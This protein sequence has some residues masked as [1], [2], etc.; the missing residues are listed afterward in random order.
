VADFEE[1]IHAG[2]KMIWSLIQ[3][4]GCRFHLTQSWWRKIQEIGL[5]DVYKNKK[6]ESGI[7]LRKIFGL[8]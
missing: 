7:W 1:S 8:S 4:I 3:V 2:A 6:C 5:T